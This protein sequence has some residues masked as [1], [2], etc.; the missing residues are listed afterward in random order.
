M[1]DPKDLSTWTPSVSL[2]L[3]YSVPVLVKTRSGMKASGYELRRFVLAHRIGVDDFDAPL[4]AA[5]FGGSV[6]KLVEACGKGL[7]KKLQDAAHGWPIRFRGVSVLRHPA[8][9]TP[10]MDDPRWV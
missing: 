8:A 3:D 7:E 10:K 2:R 1:S 9:E 4:S 6:E 5:G